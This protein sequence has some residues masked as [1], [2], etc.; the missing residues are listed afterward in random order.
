MILL[1]LKSRASG[2]CV[3]GSGM[4]T[5]N[6][7]A[8]LRERLAFD[9]EHRRRQMF[10]KVHYFVELF[11]SNSRF[12]FLSKAKKNRDQDKPRYNKSIEFLYIDTT[13]TTIRYDA[14]E[15]KKTVHNLKGANHSASRDQFVLEVY[16]AP[17]CLVDA[18]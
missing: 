7:F 17:T 13:Y 16:G 1:E 2:R 14:L 10:T 4:V 6:P 11:H 15:R 12:S 3:S 9:V 8:E 5:I 18:N